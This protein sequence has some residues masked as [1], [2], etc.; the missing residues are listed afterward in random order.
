MDIEKR[1]R[2]GIVSNGTAGRCP[3][4]VRPHFRHPGR[5]GSVYLVQG[6]FRCFWKKGLV[7]SVPWAGMGKPG[8]ADVVFRAGVS[9][10]MSARPFRRF[11]T[12]IPKIFLGSLFFQKKPCLLPFFVFGPSGKGIARGSLIFGWP[13]RSQN[14]LPSAPTFSMERFYAKCRACRFGE[15]AL[16]RGRLGNSSRMYSKR[17][18]G[19]SFRPA[20]CQSRHNVC[21]AVVSETP[22]L[23]V[24]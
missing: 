14:L 1:Q 6:H 13:H 21:A 16:C 3:L 23:V 19:F 10:I 17:K 22:V 12:A 5:S 11:R 18:A 20:R 8:P 7:L 4:I 9:N 24:K 15:T 2:Q